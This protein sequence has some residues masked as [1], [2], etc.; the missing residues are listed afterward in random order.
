MS[1]LL[2]LH[3]ASVALRGRDV[4]R[5]VSLEVAPGE[6]VALL[7]PNGAGKTTL[8]RAGLGLV[9]LNAGVATLGAS[10]SR[11]LSARSRALRAGYLPQRPQSIWP[12]SVEALVALGRY[13]HGAAPDRLGPRDQAAV[14]AAIEACGLSALRRRRMD[15]ISGGEKARAHLARALAQEAPL[16]LLDEPTAGLDPAQALAVADILRARAGRGMGIVFSTHDVSLAAAT[17][18]RVLLLRGGGVIADGAPQA[19]LTPEALEAAYAR[20][21]RLERVNETMVAIFE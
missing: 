6:I 18:H 19:A 5:G 11:G 3:D 15:E 14:D 4:L 10:A 12:I 20:K 16:L 21:G 8:L 17:A 7:G 2:S 1:A 13:A 9:P